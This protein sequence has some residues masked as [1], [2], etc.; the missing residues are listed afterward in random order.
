MEKKTPYNPTNQT[1]LPISHYTELLKK[2]FPA[3]IAE[4]TGVRV[5][6]NR[7]YITVLGEDRILTWPEFEDEGWSAY[8]RILFMRYLHEGK[9]AP[10]FSR[11]VTYKEMPWGEVYDKNFTAR[12][13]NRM[14]RMY[15]T[16]EEKFCRAC[17]ALGGSKVPSSGT[18]YELCFLPG[19]YLR[20]ILWEGDDEFPA[21]T[22]ILF[23]D[24]FAEV[25]SAEDRVVVCECTLSRMK[26]LN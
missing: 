26:K 7:F 20:L 18:A 4:R 12:C 6:E 23:S 3:E 8:D 9:R 17:E 24:N 25:F 11:Y 1:E 21:S 16:D 15:G 5:E 13:L 14:A 19:L 22:Q 10:R 2:Q